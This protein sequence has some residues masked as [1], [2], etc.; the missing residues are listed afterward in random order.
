MDTKHLKNKD[1][2]SDEIEGFSVF[3]QVCDALGI[4]IIK[5]YSAQAKG[6]VERKHQVFQDRFLKDLKL[7]GIKTI[8]EANQYRK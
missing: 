1:A 4:K 3:Q 5:A 7:Y 6:R 2:D 8:E